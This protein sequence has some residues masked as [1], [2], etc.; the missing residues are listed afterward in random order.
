MSIAHCIMGIPRSQGPINIQI[1]DVGLCLACSNS[2]KELG[3]LQI[4]TKFRDLP[5]AEKYSEIIHIRA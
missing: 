4:F 1:K 5:Q 2:T 3:F